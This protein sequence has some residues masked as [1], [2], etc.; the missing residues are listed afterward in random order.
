LPSG[1]DALAARLRRQ[2]AWCGRDGSPLYADLLENAASDIEVEGPVW[3]V[4]SGFEDEPGTAA[5]ALR[6][7]AAVH[8]LVLDGTLPELARHYPSTGGAGEA[9]EA[10]PLFRQALIDHG[11]DVRALVR[12]PCQ[13]NEVG[14]SAALLGGFLEVAHRTG[15]PLRIL[16]IGASAGLNLR[17]D[18]YRYEAADGA[19][20][21]Q[22]SPVTFAHHFDVPPPMSRTADVVERTGCDVNPIDPATEDGALALRSSIWADQ[23]GRLALLDGAIEVAGDVPVEIEAA[24]AVSFLQRRLAR[25]ARGVATVVYHSVVMQYVAED[26]RTRI[27]DAIRGAGVFHLSMEPVP[28]A[29]EIRL[30]GE[31]LGTAGPHGTRV[32]WNVDSTPR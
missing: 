27:D 26:D 21:E 30:D 23:L 32:R 15:L 25:P 2:A 13:T 9:H 7:M 1:R 17:W 12:R 22:G 24:D 10:W 3:H 4:L 11:D 6:F 5:V 8:R 16:E 31:L 14:R 18:H 19:W 20:G 28:N 29:F